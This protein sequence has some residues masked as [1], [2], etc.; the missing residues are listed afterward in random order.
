MNTN[1]RIL[2]AVSVILGIVG[3]ILGIDWIQRSIWNARQTGGQPTQNSNGDLN[4]TKAP[5]QIPAGSVPIY[6]D[7]V[8][9]GGFSPADL[10]KLE[11]ASFVDAEEGKLQ[12][13]WLLKDVILLAFPADQIRADAEIIVSSSSRKKSISLPWAEITDP[14]NMVM[15]DLSNR[16]TVKLVSLLPQLDARDEWI[17][18]VDRIEVHTK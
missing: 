16:G 2:I 5:V 3:A 15:F 1:T 12:D 18:D 7:G 13:G 14:E 6:L 8:L 11:K 17:Q 10:E 9:V 4:E